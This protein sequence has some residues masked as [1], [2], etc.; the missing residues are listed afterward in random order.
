MAQSAADRP[1]RWAHD[2]AGSAYVLTVTPGRYLKTVRT[3]LAEYQRAS[4]VKQ[5]QIFVTMMHAF[6]QELCGYPPTSYGVTTT[7]C[8]NTDTGSHPH[9]VPTSYAANATLFYFTSS[10]DPDDVHDLWVKHAQVYLIDPPQG[11]VAAAC[12]T[13]VVFTDLFLID[14]A[15]KD[16]ITGAW[17]LWSVSDIEAAQGIRIDLR[18]LENETALAPTVS[19]VIQKRL[20]MLHYQLPPDART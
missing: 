5:P 3:L 1:S 9:V 20:E 2:A 7:A 17:H 16:P 4:S 14:G 12:A 19:H 8:R 13:Q 15:S 6:M 10:A 11:D 18:I